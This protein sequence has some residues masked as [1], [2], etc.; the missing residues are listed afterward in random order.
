M[1]SERTA[2][3]TKRL[4]IPSFPYR[5]CTPLLP[6]E[7]LFRLEQNTLWIEKICGMRPV[8]FRCPRLFGSTAVCLA[9]EE[10][11]YLSDASYPMYFYRDRLEPY[12]PSPEDWT[13]P[14]DM[15]L[16][17]I[18][19]F[20]NLALPS[21]DEFGRD[22]DQWPKFRT[23]SAAALL[24][25]IA[26][27]LDFLDSRGVRRKVLAFYFHPWEFHPMPGGLIR[28]GEGAVLPDPF[29]VKNCGRYALEQFDLLL[30]GLRQRGA[31]F[32]TAA[33]IARDT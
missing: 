4:A 18:P 30:T 17:Q 22:R 27:F 23:E 15:R 16:V 32:R 10:L 11:G 24:G 9:L 12:H 3:I 1:K 5:A 25:H 14:G 31:S 2:S 8:S 6:S 33:E 21:A 26:Q 29:I 7:V 13:K 28:F 20:A 19:N